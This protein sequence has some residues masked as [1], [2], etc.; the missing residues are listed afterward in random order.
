MSFQT[1]LMQLIFGEMKM[2]HKL[3]KKVRRFLMVVSEGALD[4][5][6]GDLVQTYHTKHYWDGVQLNPDGTPRRV[7]Y[8]CPDPAYHRPNSAKA[9]YKRH[10]KLF[11]ELKV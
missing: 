2:S 5:R 10:K 3:A 6:K 1:L 9:E 4:V 11:K 7:P 8:L